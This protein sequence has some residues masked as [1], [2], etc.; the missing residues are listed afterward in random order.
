MWKY[1]TAKNTLKYVDRLD[2]LQKLVKSYN[3]SRHRS[4][5]MRPVDV[6]KDN[7]NVVWERLYGK[8]SYKPIRFKVNVGDQVRISKTRRT[9]KKGYLASWTEEVLTKRILRRPPVYK[10]ADYE[11]EELEGTF[12]EQELQK[13]S[14]TDDDYYRVEKILESRMRNKRKEYFFKF[15]GYLRSLAL[16]FA[17]KM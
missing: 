4:I 2:I 12:Y 11:G 15:L 5:G 14:K 3:H 13:V 10:I 1:L 8:E 6:N 16:G 9:F 17:Q 7:E